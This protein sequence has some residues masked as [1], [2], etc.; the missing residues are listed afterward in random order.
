LVHCAIPTDETLEKV[1]VIWP[2]SG[3]QMLTNVSLNRYCQIVE[4]SAAP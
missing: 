1:E 2:N 4:P 3:P